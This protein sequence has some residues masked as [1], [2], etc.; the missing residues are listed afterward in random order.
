MIERLLSKMG[1]HSHSLALRAVAWCFFAAHVSLWL[2]WESLFGS[3]GLTPVATSSNKVVIDRSGP[4]VLLFFGCMASLLA[5]ILR[6]PVGDS[7]LLRRATAA[8]LFGVP[9]LTYNFLFSKATGGHSPFL[10]FQWDI[11]LLEVGFALNLALLFVPLGVESSRNKGAT[12]SPLSP[13]GLWLLRFAAFKLMLMSG[14]VKIHADDPT[15]LELTATEVHFA[16]QCLP[17]PLSWL[18]NTIFPPFAHKLNVAITM[19]LECL[20]GTIILLVGPLV[21]DLPLGWVSSFG[22]TLAAFA[23]GGQAILQLLIITSG[24]YNFFNVLTIALCAFCLPARSGDTSLSAPS[25]ALHLSLIAAY[26]GWT[27]QSMFDYNR[28]TGDFRLNPETHGGSAAYNTMV[29]DRFLPLAILFIGWGGYALTTAWFCVQQVWSF[30]TGYLFAPCNKERSVKGFGVLFYPLRLLKGSVALLIF[31]PLQL[32]AVTTVLGASSLMLLTLRPSLFQQEQQHQQQGYG[33]TRVISG[34]LERTNVLGSLKSTLSSLRSLQPLDSLWSQGVAFSMS[35]YQ[36][37]TSQDDGNGVLS[38]LRLT[39]GYGLFRVMTGVGNS[40]NAGNHPHE[41]SYDREG[42]LVPMPPSTAHP[43]RTLFFKGDSQRQRGRKGHSAASESKRERHMRQ[44]AKQSGGL[45]AAKPW[46]PR[47]AEGKPVVVTRRPEL[48]VE[49][50]WLGSDLLAGINS[51]STAAAPMVG[52]SPAARHVARRVQKWLHRKRDMDVDINNDILPLAPTEAWVEVPLPYKPAVTY[53]YHYTV[54]PRQVAPH[55]PRLDWQFWFAALVGEGEGEGS[56]D[57]SAVLQTVKNQQAVRG[58][59]LSNDTIA[60]SAFPE[61]MPIQ[62]HQRPEATAHRS[63]HNPWLVR[64]LDGLL[65]GS[66]SS[67]SLIDPDLYPVKLMHSHSS[68]SD[69]KEMLA[70]VPPVAVR[71]RQLYLDFTTLEGSRINRRKRQVEAGTELEPHAYLPLQAGGTEYAYWQRGPAPHGKELFFP[72]IMRNSEG[73]AS[74]VAFLEHH[75]WEKGGGR[76]LFARNGSGSGPG[77]IPLFPSFPNRAPGSRGVRQQDGK[78]V[79]KWLSSLASQALR[80][81]KQLLTRAMRPWLK[82]SRLSLPASLPAAAPLWSSLASSFPS[83]EAFEERMGRALLLALEAGKRVQLFPPPS[84]GA[85]YFAVERKVVATTST[86][87]D[88]SSP[89]LLVVDRELEASNYDFHLAADAAATAADGD[90][91]QGRLVS[92][93]ETVL[94]PL[95]VLPRSSLAMP[96]SGAP[97]LWGLVIASLLLLLKDAFVSLPLTTVTVTMAVKPIDTDDKEDQCKTD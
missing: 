63:A 27:W 8:F 64:F 26:V 73:A 46:P 88:D 19:W 35:S 40:E 24:N 58:I 28:E 66:P 91:D 45:V 33:Q 22:R 25:R 52:L 47:D 12:S 71:V 97:V 7:S 11:L 96:L 82:L 39:S 21:A 78:V 51:N 34:A 32:T 18:L 42:R 3:A 94:A 37:L 1:Q 79:G 2:Q 84:F 10:S 77:V 61:P 86:K 87:S 20:P 16:S 4:H 90:K 17:N 93:T 53:P 31:L 81:G 30:V 67:F 38:G 92:S 36:L 43:T 41:E 74:V 60:P 69:N 6:L 68:N 54:R 85:G 44:L 59:L 55:Q 57:D 70:F 80:G 56:S 83:F 48:V 15:W 89:S 65:H 5:C 75:G 62:P 49:G 23:F 13:T 29:L 72:A 14:S 76:P 95:L 50:L 9:T